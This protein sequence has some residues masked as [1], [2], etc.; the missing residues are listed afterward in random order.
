MASPVTVN[1]EAYCKAALHAAKYF[2]KPVLGVLLVSTSSGGDPESKA[3]DGRAIAVLD[4]LPL[5][6]AYAAP[7]V[8][9]AAMLQVNSAMCS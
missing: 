4:S 2:A 3:D 6:H 8:I 9:E 5:S 1:A 7:S